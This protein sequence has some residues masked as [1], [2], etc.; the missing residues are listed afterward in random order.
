MKGAGK[1]FF[2]IFSEDD[3]GYAAHDYS[4][5]PKSSGWRT[6]YPVRSIYLPFPHGTAEGLPEEPAVQSRPLRADKSRCCRSRKHPFA[7]SG[8]ATRHVDGIHEAR[9]KGIVRKVLWRN[10]FKNRRQDIHM[11]ANGIFPE[12]DWSISG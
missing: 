1:I 8:K 5:F 2:F 7:A 12:R 6:R 3:A 9:H 11:T 10:E 4:S